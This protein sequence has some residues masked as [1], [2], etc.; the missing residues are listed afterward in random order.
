MSRRQIFLKAA[1]VAAFLML[2]I[3]NYYNPMG[4]RGHKGKDDPSS[5]LSPAIFTFQIWFVIYSL[6]LGFVIYQWFDSA[7]DA[8]VDGVQYYHI[9][10][11]VLSVA[12]RYIWD[13]EYYL[14]DAF[15]ILSMFLVMF[16]IYYNLSSFYP[17]KNVLDLLF[18]RYPFT[19]YTGWLLVSTVL[20]FWIAVSALDTIVISTVAVVILGF[21]GSYFTDDDRHDVVFAA[22]I[23]WALIGIAVKNHN[24]MPIL[25]AALVLSGLNVGGILRVWERYFIAKIRLRRQRQATERS[26]LLG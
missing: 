24:N 12:W 21:I 23:L 11:C 13:Q 17:P 3:F 2:L 7:N 6:L 5:Y 9:I 19:I 8:T 18:I 10:A 15:V 16:K 20:N 1:N 14:L 26:P 25:V 22:T 4:K